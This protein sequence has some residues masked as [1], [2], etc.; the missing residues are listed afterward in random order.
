LASKH[1]EFK[2]LKTLGMVFSERQV[3]DGPATTETR[4]Y[5][6]SCTWREFLTLFSYSTGRLRSRCR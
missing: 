5:I 2:G 6:N 3:G 4:L 1:A